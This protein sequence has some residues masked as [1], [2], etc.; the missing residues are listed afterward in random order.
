MYKRVGKRRDPEKAIED[1][2]K[3][4]LSPVTKTLLSLQE[5]RDARNERR[6]LKESGDFLGVQGFNPSTG[7]PDVMTPSDSDQSA[8]G[9]EIEEKLDALKQLSKNASSP[10]SKKR[11]DKEIRKVLLE[12]ESD[13]FARRE[14]AKAA[15]QRAHSN[16][17]WRKHSK[18]WSSAQAPDLSPI[19]QSQTSNTPPLSQFSMY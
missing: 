5:K 16:L 8:T 17:K 10:S 19:A 9:Q 18:Q 14:Q 7:V 2:S 3:P 12:K 11:I 6:S 15:L 4:P 1:A 13:K